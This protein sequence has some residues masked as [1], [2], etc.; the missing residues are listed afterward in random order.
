M[1]EIKNV[2]APSPPIEQN[3][4]KIA[5]DAVKFPNG[6]SPNAAGDTA[7]GRGTAGQPIGQPTTEPT[8]Q[9]ALM[10]NVV[11]GR[12][13]SQLIAAE[14]MRSNAGHSA[15]DVLL[16]LNRQPSTLGTMLAPPGNLEALRHLTPT[17]R[18]TILRNLLTKQRGQMRRLVAVMRDDERQTPDEEN[19]NEENAGETPAI[20]PPVSAAA[21]YNQR[22]VQDLEAT[23]RMLDLLDELLGMQD[24]TLSQMG[25][26]AQG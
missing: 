2:G 22:A 10:P 6:Q 7:V 11:T 14:K 25:T 24:Y 15:T 3:A 17:M 1:A 9:N 16:G 13:P 5:D 20:L 26:F 21:F 23:T 12:D 4:A 18:R 8:T 19:Q